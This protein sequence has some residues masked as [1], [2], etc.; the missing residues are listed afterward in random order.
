M[1]EQKGELSRL[2]L[3]SSATGAPID[4]ALNSLFA[5]APPVAPKRPLAAPAP[6]PTV[7]AK[8]REEQTASAK[9]PKKMKQGRAKDMQGRAKDIHGKRGPAAARPTKAEPT[10]AEPRSIDVARA[11]RARLMGFTSDDDSDGESS[12]DEVQKAKKAEKRNLLGRMPQDPEVLKRTVFVGNLS[13]KSI[14]D[15]KVYSEL[16][17]L[18]K[19][20]GPIKGI[21]FRSIAFSELL[22]RKVAFIRGKFHSERHACNAYIEFKDEEAATKALELNGAEFQD[23]HLRV[24]SANNDKPYDMKR[25]VFVGNLDF[26]AEEEDLWKH[27]GSCG[28][29]ENVRIIRDAK[30]NMGKGFAYV[31]FADRAD[32]GL[33]LKLAGTEVNSRKLRVQRASEKAAKAARGPEKG[34]KGRPVA[35]RAVFEGTRSVKGDKPSN[36]KRRTARSK[37]YAEKLLNGAKPR[38]QV[39]KPTRDA[40]RGKPKGRTRP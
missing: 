38:G 3:G 8:P 31:Q 6:F 7:I 2:L 27:F 18:C 5:N 4:N 17:E 15:N 9:R 22:P 32:V 25:S 37:E 40:S 16:R 26:A 30:T 13:I 10:K 36:K 11:K 12:E 34:A 35:A 24:D 39:N 21:R 23:R 33:A 20:Y 19:K 14:T 28:T 29:V 1:A